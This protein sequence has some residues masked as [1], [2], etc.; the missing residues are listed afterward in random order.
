LAKLLIDSGV[1]LII[2]P[3]VRFEGQPGEQA[4]MFFLDP[5][6]NPLEFKAFRDI[7]TQLFET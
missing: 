7:E 1:D 2:A 4:T 6:G 5:S 3:Y